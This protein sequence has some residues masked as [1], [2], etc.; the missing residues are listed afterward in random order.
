MR[1]PE[2][3]TILACLGIAALW[4]ISCGVVAIVKNGNDFGDDLREIYSAAL[5]YQRG[6][7]ATIY[8]E[9]PAEQTDRTGIDPGRP[10]NFGYTQP[11]ILAAML[12][13]V[14]V[15]IPFDSFNEAFLFLDVF[16]YAG[17]LLIALRAWRPGWCRPLAY[18]GLLALVLLSTPFQS[19]EWLNQIQ[20]IV[21]L[22]IVSALMFEQRGWNGLAGAAAAVAIMLKVSPAVILVAWLCAGRL[23]PILWTIGLGLVLALLNVVVCGLPLCL[24]FLARLSQ[25]SQE[26]M[27][28]LNNQ[29]L[30]S[31]SFGRLHAASY[32]WRVYPMPADIVWIERA[33]LLASAASIAFLAIRLRGEIRLR[34]LTVFCLAASLVVVPLS[35]D[36]YSIIMPVLLLALPPEWL[37]WQRSGHWRQKAW[38]LV[39]AAIVL[40]EV[41]PIAPILVWSKLYAAV[42]LAVAIVVLVPPRSGEAAAAM[43]PDRYERSFQRQPASG[44]TE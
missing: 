44:M 38:L 1:A 27:V 40:L 21:V 29:S 13:P 35:W 28:A 24:A 31:F 34:A 23:R 5:A 6:D 10:L 39:A 14:A 41:F 32:L 26:V 2:R 30:A 42:I 9:G 12:A 20:M 33:S 25:L 17:G 11:P 3:R 8:H 4:T 7:Q 18:T 16:A 15:R 22:L 36:H 37:G 19:A 43:S